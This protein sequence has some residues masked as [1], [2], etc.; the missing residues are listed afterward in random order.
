MQIE[1]DSY[2]TIKGGDDPS[3]VFAIREYREGDRLQRIHWKLSYET[4]SAN[5][6]GF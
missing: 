1:S 2:S 3:E 5:D 6:K 4:K